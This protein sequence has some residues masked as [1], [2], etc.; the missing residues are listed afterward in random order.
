MG[1]GSGVVRSVEVVEALMGE[2]GGGGGGEE[3]GGV[4]AGESVCW[5]EGGGG[6]GDEGKVDGG[7]RGR[8]EIL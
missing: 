7:W 6:L 4:E 5:E 2:G 1:G 3:V 8:A